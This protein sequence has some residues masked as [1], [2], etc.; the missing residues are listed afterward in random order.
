MS[1]YFY[2]LYFADSVQPA[3][4]R[5]RILALPEVKPDPQSP[6]Q[7]WVGRVHLVLDCEDAEEMLDSI[8]PR[9]GIRTGSF[10]LDV[11][12]HSFSQ[13]DTNLM[14]D[15]LMDILAEGE[16]A[17]AVYL[18]ERIMLMQKDGK[19]YVDSSQ[20]SKDSVD[21]LRRRRECQEKDLGP[22]L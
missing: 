19:L 7:F 9:T 6:D 4:L 20:M 21:Q 22:I 11:G 17:V 2:E 14:L 13:A 10:S 8:E 18:S 5:E 15:V 3:T 12:V 1:S 16:D